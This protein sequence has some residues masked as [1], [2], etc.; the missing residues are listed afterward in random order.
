MTKN[1]GENSNIL[2][3]AKANKEIE[4][5]NAEIQKI[6]S[7]LSKRDM[8]YYKIKEENEF[9]RGKMILMVKKANIYGIKLE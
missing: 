5:L 6:N 8:E 4:K 2:E 1:S 3:L 7:K 9:L